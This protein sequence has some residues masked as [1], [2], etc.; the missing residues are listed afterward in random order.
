MATLVMLSVSAEFIGNMN[1]FT[2]AIAS[3]KHSDKLQIPRRRQSLNYHLDLLPNS[4]YDNK[5]IN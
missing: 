2:T 4:G 5:L 3:G 1:I